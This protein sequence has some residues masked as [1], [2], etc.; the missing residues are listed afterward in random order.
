MSD[1]G[2]SRQLTAGWLAHLVQQ[3]TESSLALRWQAWSEGFYPD[4]AA[5]ALRG[6]RAHGDSCGYTLDQLHCMKLKGPDDTPR[7]PKWQFEPAVLRYMPHILKTLDRM[8]SWN[9][10]CFFTEMN[11]LLGTSPLNA[12]RANQHIQVLEAALAANEDY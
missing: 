7:Y 6:C 8:N 1:F 12:L 3:S 9:V 4:E 11:D 2:Q 10:F 5:A